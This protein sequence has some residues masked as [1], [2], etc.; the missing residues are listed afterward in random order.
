[1]N[2]DRGGSNMRK[3]S[4]VRSFTPTKD[5][6]NKGTSPLTY[7]YTSPH[8][9]KAIISSNSI[10][11]TDC[12]FMNDKS[13]YVHIQKPLLTALE[14]IENELYDDSIKDTVINMFNDNYETERMVITMRPDIKTKL[15]IIKQ[16][17]YIFCTTS[18]KDSL[19]MWNYYVK[20][21]NYQGYNLGLQ[22]NHIIKSFSRLDDENIT[23]FYGNVIY[24][25]T[26]KIEYLKSRIL[27]I[28][29]TLKT[30][31]ENE[32]EQEDYPGEIYDLAKGEL[33]DFIETAR[34]FF[35]D[36]SFIN[37]SEYRFIIKLPKDYNETSHPVLNNGYDVRGGIIVPH[38]ILNVDK[39]V[40]KS[41]VISPIL[42]KELAEQGFQ[43]FLHSCN[44]ENKLEI[45]QSK[46]PIR[47]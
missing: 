22:I 8:G 15:Q 30:R 25:D 1:M 39:S 24:K 23:L 46:I 35:K 31:I 42:E 11:F 27:S 28:D 47:Y 36:E 19:N 9:A 41:I 3:S 14:Q 21:G 4:E 32:K 12:Q 6:L 16:R 10:R 2:C 7:H 37:E 29:Q 43:R 5:N 18:L 17:Y 33:L 13:E 20:D 40:F 38:C 45:L 26:E 34:L 44:Y